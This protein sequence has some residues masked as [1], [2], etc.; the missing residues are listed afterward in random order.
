MD[1]RILRKLPQGVVVA[2]PAALAGC[3]GNKTEMVF[4]D[5]R[6]ASRAFSKELRRME[7]AP[8]HDKWGTCPLK[9]DLTPVYQSSSKIRRESGPKT[10]KMYS[11]K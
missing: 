4:V 9:A 2:I 6:A 3:Y 7:R 10:Y 11:L 5:W 1:I 8:M